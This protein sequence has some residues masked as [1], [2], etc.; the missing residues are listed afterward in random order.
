[1]Q[2]G[3]VACRGESGSWGADP[4]HNLRIIQLDGR[5]GRQS[6]ALRSS[7]AALCWASRSHCSAISIWSSARVHRGLARRE[8]GIPPRGAYNVPK[9]AYG[10]AITRQATPL[11]S[12]CC[13]LSRRPRLFVP[14][15]ATLIPT[16]QPP[17]SSRYFR[18]WPVS[19]LGGQVENR[20]GR[21]CMKRAFAELTLLHP[22]MSWKEM[23]KENEMFRAAYAIAIAALL[24]TAASGVSQAAPISPL[25]PGVASEAASGHVIDA[26]CCRRRGW[27]YGP[28]RGYGAYRGYYGYYGYPRR[29]W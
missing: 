4:L 9:S 14:I 11:W 16:A 10:P 21:F 13:R 19:G 18:C 3:L 29:G 2:R 6:A 8:R 20:I 25:P 5:L 23:N 12:K 27:G 1:M 17:A 28:Y 26:W 24:L 7:T 22:I 15:A